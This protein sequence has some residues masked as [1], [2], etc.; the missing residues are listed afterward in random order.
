MERVWVYE[1]KMEVM[2]TLSGLYINSNFNSHT[3]TTY[4]Y[5]QCI[6]NSW[7][8]WCCLLHTQLCIEHKVRVIGVSKSDS[9]THF[10]FMRW[11]KRV[12]QPTALEEEKCTSRTNVWGENASHVR[13]RACSNGGINLKSGPV[14]LG[15]DLGSVPKSSVKLM[16]WW[17]GEDPLWCLLAVPGWTTRWRR[18]QGPHH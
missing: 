10:L 12:S 17:E 18:Q 13:L 15:L 3:Q 14:K 5:L 2:Y 7:G 11:W 4:S 1:L 8:H 6:N 9:E 16:E